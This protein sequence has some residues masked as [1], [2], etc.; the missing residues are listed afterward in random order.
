MSTLAV[1]SW[2]LRVYC[3]VSDGA[4][5]RLLH[6]AIIIAARDAGL[7]GASVLRAKMGF[8]RGG[9]LY[10]DLLSEVFSDRQPVIVEIIDQPDRINAF[11]PALHAL[12]RGRR[13]I[14]AER[15]EIMLYKPQ[16]S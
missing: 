6:E 7:A 13:L 8:G 3:V 1:E 2:L 5:D 4:G 15:A 10:S 11:L 12:V 14:T 16:P 9:F